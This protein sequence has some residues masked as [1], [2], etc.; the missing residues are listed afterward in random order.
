MRC[1]PKNVVDTGECETL[2]LLQQGGYLH[3]THSTHST[4]TDAGSLYDL[5]F[6]PGERALLDKMAIRV[7]CG[8]AENDVNGSWDR[9]S[10]AGVAMTIRGWCKHERLYIRPG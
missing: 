1:P 10:P 4:I 8:E 3:L 2:R 6:I 9:L 7:E 5:N